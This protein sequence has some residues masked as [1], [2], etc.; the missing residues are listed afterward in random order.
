MKAL[1]LAL[2]LTLA[3]L[4][5]AHATDSICEAVALHA[6]SKTEMLDA[7]KVGEKICYHAV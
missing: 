5:P 7:L 1:T 6:T 2:A 4:V 3:T